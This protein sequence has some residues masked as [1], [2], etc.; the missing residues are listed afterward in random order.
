MLEGAGI[1]FTL[2]AYFHDECEEGDDTCDD[3]K[4]LAWYY[5]AAA[6]V[7][8]L[9]VAFKVYFSLV[10]WRFYVELRDENVVMVDD[11][12]IIHIDIAPHPAFGDLSQHA[13]K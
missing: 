4:E 3:D 12:H 6:A 9:F 2:F 10:I 1:V 5:V 8:A 13:K 7:C 11:S